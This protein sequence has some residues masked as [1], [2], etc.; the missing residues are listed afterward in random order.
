M[1]GET[2]AQV[3]NLIRDQQNE[4]MASQ[5]L[6]QLHQMLGSEDAVVPRYPQGSEGEA[7]QNHEVLAGRMDRMESTLA[8]QIVPALSGI[9]ESIQVLNQRLDAVLPAAKATATETDELEA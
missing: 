6:A 5:D 1:D 7:S 3:A 4:K 2:I 9:A 8:G